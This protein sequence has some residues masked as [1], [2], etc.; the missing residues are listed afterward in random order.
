M[1]EQVR[2]MQHEIAETRAE[3]EKNFRDLRAGIALVQESLGV[4]ETARGPRRRSGSMMAEVPSRLVPTAA[5]AYKPPAAAY[6]RFPDPSGN[7]PAYRFPSPSTV[8]DAQ[9]G[10][11]MTQPLPVAFARTGTVADRLVTSSRGMTPRT[12]PIDPAVP[13]Q[14]GGGRPFANTTIDIDTCVAVMAKGDW[15]YKWSSEASSSRD[16]SPRYVWLD[17]S[18]YVLKWGKKHSSVALFSDFIKLE[19]IFDVASTVLAEHTEYGSK[20]IYM[21]VIRAPNRTLRLGSEKR[22]KID[23][24]YDA[25]SNVIAFYRMQGYFAQRFAGSGD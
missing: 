1:Q 20:M 9:T 12:T 25:I 4:T 17:A 5:A 3:Q 19:L 18:S 2:R 7:M 8:M 21:L 15:F 10:T 13:V 6:H 22:H 23:L 11:F 16:V 14:G 24:W